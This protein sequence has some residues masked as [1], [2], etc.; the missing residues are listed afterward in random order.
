MAINHRCAKCNRVAFKDTYRNGGT[1]MCRKCA[2]VAVAED[3]GRPNPKGSRSTVMPAHMLDDYE[4]A[5][6]DNDLVS[7]R[8]DLATYEARQRQLLKQVKEDPRNSLSWA[9][10]LSKVLEAMEKRIQSGSMTYKD[11]FGHVV[12]FMETPVKDKLIWNEIH[13]VTE[14]RRKMAHTEAKRLKDL[15]WSPDMVLSMFS[16]LAEFLK[17]LL[18]ELHYKQLLDFIAQ[19]KLF[20]ANQFDVIGHVELTTK[21]MKDQIVAQDISKRIINTEK[22]GDTYEA[23]GDRETL[24]L[25][26]ADAGSAGKARKAKAGSKDPGNIDT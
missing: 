25:P 1:P 18:A 6:I 8:E 14:L 9:T 26:P 5:L 15:G 24:H 3:K 7:M 23:A 16:E 12:E 19:S 10:V 4:A 11:A 17:P 20:N 13:T 2:G 22:K 21:R